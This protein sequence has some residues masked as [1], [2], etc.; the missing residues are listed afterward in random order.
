MAISDHMISGSVIPIR[1]RFNQ[2]FDRCL[3]HQYRAI[4]QKFVCFC[5]Y[6]LDRLAVWLTG[7]G[8]RTD[9]P[10]SDWRSRQAKMHQTL[11]LRGADRLLRVRLRPMV[12][13]RSKISRHPI[14]PSADIDHADCGNRTDPFESNRRP[15]PSG[16]PSAICVKSCHAFSHP[17]LVEYMKR[18]SADQRIYRIEFPPLPTRADGLH[19]TLQ[20]IRIR[21]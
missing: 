21:K 15:E 18:P 8:A 12:W 14:R 5:V 19:H 6:L 11:V 3:R 4:V 13:V 10:S 7:S 1:S 9:G 16:D 2:R 20:P 17:L